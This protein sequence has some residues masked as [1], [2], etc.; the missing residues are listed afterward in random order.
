[1]FGVGAF[2]SSKS[3]R[4]P[5]PFLLIVIAG[6]WWLC[7]KRRILRHNLRC[8]RPVAVQTV[9]DLVYVAVFSGKRLYFPILTY[10]YLQH[11][12]SVLNVGLFGLDLVDSD[13]VSDVVDD[14]PVGGLPHVQLVGFVRN[15]LIVLILE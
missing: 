14:K 4:L 8:T 10:P 2:V 12:I 1:M 3:R 5:I 9:V 15:G 7:S 6:R 11:P 13:P